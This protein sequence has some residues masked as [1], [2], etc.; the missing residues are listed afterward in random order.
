MERSSIRIQG[1]PPSFISIRSHSFFKSSSVNKLG[2]P[3]DSDTLQDVRIRM[4]LL[5]AFYFKGLLMLL[6][7]ISDQ[8][9]NIFQG[10]SQG[11]CHWNS[12]HNKKR[13]YI[14]YLKSADTQ[15]G[16]IFSTPPSR[17]EDR[18]S[19]PSRSKEF[20]QGAELKPFNGESGDLGGEEEDKI[21]ESGFFNTQRTFLDFA[22]SLGFHS[23]PMATPARKATHTGSRT[24]IK[25]S[26]VGLSSVRWNDSTR[27]ITRWANG[28]WIKEGP[29]QV[30]R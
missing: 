5:N 28:Q 2:L 13:D 25:P 29:E 22:Q 7:R 20:K 21:K 6:L 19:D 9:R 10:N 17:T 30:S 23:H 24:E 15:G 1:G 26:I 14:S 27:A 18:E 11:I 16:D 4:S 12:S 3:L 8:P